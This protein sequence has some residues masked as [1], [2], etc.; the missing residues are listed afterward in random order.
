MRYDLF[1][2]DPN[3]TNFD[4]ILETASVGNFLTSP[5]SVTVGTQAVTTPE[6]VS[7][8]LLIGGLAG[9]LLIFKLRKGRLRKGQRWAMA[10]SCC[11]CA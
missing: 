3:A 5:A 4:P 7:L 1:R 9:G 2:V 8:V 11:G 6:P 10:R